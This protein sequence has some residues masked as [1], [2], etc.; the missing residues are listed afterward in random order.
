[1]SFVKRRVPSKGDL[2]R[3]RRS[4]GYYHF[5]IAV[6]ENTV[7]HFSAPQGDLSDNKQELMIIETP[8]SQF[9]RGDVLEI[10]EPYNSVFTPENVVKRAKNYV[11]SRYFRGKPYNFIENNC[12]HFARYCYDGD[13][14]SK[15]VIDVTTA[16]IA[17]GAAVVAGVAGAVIAKKKKKNAVVKRKD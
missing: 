9:V 3:V 8:L 12:E 17:T 15:Q 11:N 13:P 6:D 14:K 16:V 2:L 1:M 4:A 10:E 7:I 5:G